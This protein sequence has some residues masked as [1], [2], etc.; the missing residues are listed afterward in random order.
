MNYSMME[1]VWLLLIYSFLGWVVETIVGTVKKKKFVNRGFSTGPFCLVYGIAAVFMAVTMEEL[2]AEPVFQLI[3]CGVFATII[4][5][6]AG[7]ILERL[8]QHKWWDYSNKKWNFD[9]YIC[10]QYSVLWAVLGF[11]A[12]RYGDA[13]FLIVYHM[14]PTLIREILLKAGIAYTQ[15]DPDTLGFFEEEMKKRYPDLELFQLP[16]TMSIGSHTGPGALGIG[17]V[18]FHK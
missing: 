14:I 18:R 1:L 13:F 7:K 16:L 10:L 12:V 9:G 8:N 5:W 17:L 15:M 6:M 3:G 4:E 2:M 11:V